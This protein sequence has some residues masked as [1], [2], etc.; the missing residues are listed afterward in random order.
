MGKISIG[1]KLCEANIRIENLIRAKE[2]IE[3]DRKSFSFKLIELEREL[4]KVSNDKASLS[5]QLKTAM[6]KIAFYS[7]IDEL[8]LIQRT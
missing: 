1:Q 3:E 5:V 4:K 8:L 7:K 6:D 2:V